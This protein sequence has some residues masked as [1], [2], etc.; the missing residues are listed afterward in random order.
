MPEKTGT[1]T[2]F[3]TN[4]RKDN[5]VFGLRIDGDE[6]LYSFPEYRGEPFEADM[7]E[8]GCTV[9]IEY[10]DT[11]KAGKTKAYISVLEIQDVVTGPDFDQPVSPHGP[12]QARPISVHEGEVAWGFEQKDKLMCRESCAKSAVAIFAASIQAGIYK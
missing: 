7:V 12:Q 9:R 6:Y 4:P 8:V 1:V 11:E 10:Q 3:V 5:E 2:S